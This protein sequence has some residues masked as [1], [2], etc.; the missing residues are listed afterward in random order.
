MKL[1]TLL[2]TTAAVMTFAGVAVAADKTSVKAETTLEQNKNG[3]YDKD[4]TVEKSTPSG[5]VKDESETKLKVDDN[6]DSEKTTT[7]KHVNDP[8]GL[9]NKHTSKDTTK[10]KTKNGTTT[11]EHTKK[12]DGNTVIDSNST[13]R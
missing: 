11:T 3:G 4:T 8:K 9:M 7:N 13:T 6:G 10:V 2:A 12:V 1:T 5:S